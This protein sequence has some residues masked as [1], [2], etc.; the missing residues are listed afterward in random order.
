MTPEKRL[1]YGYLD[2]LSGLTWLDCDEYL[3]ASVNGYPGGPWYAGAHGYL[4]YHHWLLGMKCLWKASF[5][6]TRWWLQL[7]ILGTIKAL[8]GLAASEHTGEFKEKN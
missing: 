5:E 4:N 7:A 6:E 3:T 2:G 1:K 8:D